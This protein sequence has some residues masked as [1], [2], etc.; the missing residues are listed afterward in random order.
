MMGC[1]NSTDDTTKK[2][3]NA[4]QHKDGANYQVKWLEQFN[5]MQTNFKIYIYNNVGK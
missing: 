1:I 4:F 3:F 2:L 5:I